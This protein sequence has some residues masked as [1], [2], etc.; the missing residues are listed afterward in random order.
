V[1]E[2]NTIDL[3]E[4]DLDRPQRVHIVGVGGAGMSAIALFLARMGHTVSGSDLKE[5]PVLARLRA[6]GVT[7]HVGHDPAIITDLLDAVVYST[8]IPLTNIELAAARERAIPVL[9]RAAMLRAIVACRRSIA[10]AGSHG[11]TTTSSMLTLVLR[12]ADL[13]PSFV[14]GG[15]LNEVGTNAGYGTG[16]WLVVEADESDGTFLQ[17]TPEAAIVTNV[18]PDHLDHYGGFDGLVDAFETFT[19]RVPGTFVAC[20][21]DPVAK[22]LAS[23]HSGSRTYGETADADY[24]IVDYRSG[25]T[26]STFTL[27]GPDGEIGTVELPL[28]VRNALNA[29]GAAALALELGVEFGAVQQA[30]RTFGGVARRF[31]FR[32]E[33]DGVTFVDDYAHLPGE[34]AAAIE[35]ARE[36]AWDRVIVVFQPHRYT[37]TSA[38]WRDFSDAFTGADAVVLTD[39][40]AAG[41]QPIAGVS[42]RLLVR[43]VLDRHPAAPVSYLPRRAD[44]LDVPK[45]LARAGD[46]VLTLGAGD[47]TTLPDEWLAL[48]TDGGQ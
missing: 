40:Y 34:V 23:A 37:R 5:L 3:P 21:D 42:G 47:L 4:L 15:D 27:V 36:G 1:T 10:I 43:A 39:V 12:A 13:D 24:R 20:A 22:R 30:L 16:E 48:A 11:K 28:G 26:G 2:P 8:A 17:L 19:G 44:L 29:A 33:V 32:G 31:Q 46:L 7:V 38:L 6:A 35:T 9:H 41:E 25:R 45:R 14:I 18:E